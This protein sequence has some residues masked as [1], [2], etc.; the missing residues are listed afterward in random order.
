MSKG[1]L[2]RNFIIITTSQDYWESFLLF[3]QDYKAT[4][5]EDKL[6]HRY[7]D[8]LPSNL[9]V[10]APSVVRRITFHHQ[11]SIAAVQKKLK[12]ITT[13]CEP[14]PRDLRTKDYRPLSRT[15]YNKNLNH[16]N[17]CNCLQL[18]AEKLPYQTKCESDDTL[19]D[20]RQDLSKMESIDKKIKLESTKIE[21]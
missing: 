20:R 11:R 3:N 14:D 5:K 7:A 15:K 4:I 9:V 21:G 10:E 17:C 8:I 18:L 1:E 19:T 2:T 16:C 12:H 13:F 6:L